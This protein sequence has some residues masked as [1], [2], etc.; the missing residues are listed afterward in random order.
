MLSPS[1]PTSLPL[2]SR[3]CVLGAGALG[4][5]SVGQLVE[6]GVDRAS[7]VCYEAREDVGGLWWVRRR[8]S[9]LFLV[10]TEG[11][12]VWL[13]FKE[14]RRQPRDVRARL[15][16]FR[17]GDPSDATGEGGQVDRSADGAVQRVEDELAK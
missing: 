9:A 15:L 7:I 16:A 10:L 2:L 3:V 5:A 17:P 8:T 4:L 11:Q 13:G 14:T 1:T 6:G 12:I